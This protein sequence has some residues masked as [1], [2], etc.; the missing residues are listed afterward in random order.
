MRHKGVVEALSG[1]TSL[2]LNGSIFTFGGRTNSGFSNDVLR[3]DPNA[4]IVERIE[5]KGNKPRHRSG[6]T[7]VP[8][9]SGHEFIVFGGLSS[10]VTPLNDCWIFDISTSLLCV[11]CLLVFA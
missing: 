1:H 3:Y 5:I 2:L 9:T 11:D 10:S 8:W 4:N 7:V 6:H